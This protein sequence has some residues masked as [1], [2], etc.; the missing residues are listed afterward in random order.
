M[1]GEV[2]PNSRANPFVGVTDTT[3]LF[4]L[5]I[6][7][8]VATSLY[9]WNYIYFSTNGRAY[10]AAVNSCQGLSSTG[11]I[12]G[13]SSPLS[14]CWAR[15]MRSVADMMSGG[16][17]LTSLA[18]VLALGALPLV[19]KRRLRLALLL[20]P[21]VEMIEARLRDVAA[22]LE[23]PIP[24]VFLDSR[25]HAVGR[26][27][28]GWRRPW[29]LLTFG[30][31]P[32]AVRHAQQFDAVVAHELAHVRNKDVRKTELAVAA[33][34]ALV[35]TVVA[36][37]LVATLT[38]PIRFVAWDVVARLA[39]LT[40]VA[41][42]LRTALLRVREHEADLR[43]SSVPGIAPALVAMLE[44]R[45]DQSR[46]RLWA[47]HPTGEFRAAVVRR[48][49]LVMRA[50]ATHAMA[51]GF[52]AYLPFPALMHWWALYTHGRPAMTAGPVL[53]ALLPG[54]IL[55]G[56]LWAMGWRQ[57]IAQRVAKGTTPRLLACG[58][59]LGVGAV[60]ASLSIPL[61]SEGSRIL[62]YLTS[63]AQWLE[64]TLTVV[65]CSA[66]VVFVL[67]WTRLW[68]ARPKRGSGPATGRVRG[69]LGSSRH[70]GVLQ[71]PHRLDLGAGVAR[72]S[73]P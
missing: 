47:K 28:G 49:Q 37:Y 39:F 69:H 40:V 21:G 68:T 66:A 57:A 5:L 41:L 72:R 1:T 54:S 64:G 9:G 30:M 65:G 58:G 12:N 17:A 67:R 25:P 20:R 55:G 61:P 60:A 46:G 31:L 2:K 36:P 33:W 6:I 16:F 3:F 52:V 48:P 53:G 70:G 56:G 24:H 7:A 22:S 42:L 45:S 29:L 13:F 44:Q 32:L 8:T 18:T 10:L 51:L 4:A 62:H 27:A 35:V 43:A 50:S 59:A 26:M 34:W 38:G 15:A 11:G 63:P 73:R 23:V 14:E 19:L 71:R